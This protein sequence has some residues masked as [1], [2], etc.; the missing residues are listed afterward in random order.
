MNE[1]DN[2]RLR[3]RIFVGMALA[4]LGILFTLDNLGVLDAEEYLRFGWPVALIAY[5]TMTLAGKRS[6]PGRVWGTVALVG[7]VVL[8]GQRIGLWTAELRAFTPLLLVFLGGYIVWQTMRN[9]GGKGRETAREWRSHFDQAGANRGT[10]SE[11]IIDSGDSIQAVAVLA[12]IERR[13]TSSSFRGGE[14][15]AVLGGGQI[16][17]REAVPADGQAVIDVFAVMGGLEIRVPESWNIEVRAT[18]VLGAI[19]D[20][21]A[22]A[23]SSGPRLI[24]RG[25]VFL[26]GIEFKS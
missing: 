11:P 19:R 3:F 6:G 12:G 22:P 20:T 8:M 25:M 9:D 15:T 13:V 16:D 18:P 21:R 24:V 10:P 14:L 5:G 17:M 7:G 4:V 1:R 26:G 2:F 23:G